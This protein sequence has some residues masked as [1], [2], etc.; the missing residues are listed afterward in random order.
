MQV[1][2]HLP[3]EELKRLERVEKDADRARRMRIIILGMEGWTAP[4]VAMAV[5]LSRRI[6]QRW[7]SSPIFVDQG[8]PS[9][10]CRLGKISTSRRNSQKTLASTA[11]N[12][13]QHTGIRSRK[14]SCDDQQ[15]LNPIPGQWLLCP[16]TEVPF[17]HS[18]ADIRRA[19]LSSVLPDENREVQ[20]AD[21]SSG[22]FVILSA[23][24]IAW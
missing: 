8:R 7:L 15:S 10:K 20:P 2:S 19:Q 6:C 11:K 22:G 18:H 4:A 3:P 5:G 21:R 14:R 23:K 9:S 24:V 16:A 13:G 17:R 1:E 12:C